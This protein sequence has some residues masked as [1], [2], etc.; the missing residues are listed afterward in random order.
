MSM[1]ITGQIHFDLGEDQYIAS[2]EVSVSEIDREYTQNTR[3]IYGVDSI[4]VKKIITNDEVQNEVAWDE[5]KQAVLDRMSD[6]EI[7]AQL[8]V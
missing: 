1:T 4:D 8:D 3:G 2:V 5:E 7:F 6:K